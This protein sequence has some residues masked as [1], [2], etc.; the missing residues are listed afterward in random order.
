MIYEISHRTAYR[1]ESTVTQSQHLVH[2]APSASDRQVVQRHML[3]IEPT[4]SW[5]SDFIDYFGNPTSV[6]GI[7]NE[8]NE[9]VMHARSTVE[10][11]ARQQI[12]V[13]QSVSW[14]AVAGRI[15]AANHEVDLEVAQY[16]LPSPATPTSD[17][18]LVYAEPSFVPRRP[19]LAAAWDLT[20]RIFDDFTF[21]SQSTDISTPVV[22]VLRNRRGVCQDF[23]HLALACLRAKRIPARYV[24]GY[25]LTR[26]P[27]GMVRL[28][29][30]DASHAWIAVWAPETGWIDFDPTNRLIPSDEHIS[31]AHGREFADISPISGVLLGGGQHRVD[32]A[33]DV[34][35]VGAPKHMAETGR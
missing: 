24:S 2:L 32:V 9:L 15:A 23:A 34:V 20:C 26:P 7:D 17:A 31:Y 12:D 3:L 14:D 10:V 18:V 33:V 28:Q 29:G 5:R 6:I 1:Y 13:R 22:E 21:D 4:P 16:A 30:A 35:P 8:H 25:I 19:I 27:P 11:T